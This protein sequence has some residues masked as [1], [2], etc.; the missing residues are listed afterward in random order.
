[1]NEIAKCM[2]IGSALI[3]INCQLAQ[4]LSVNATNTQEWPGTGQTATDAL[5]EKASTTDNTQ[6]YKLYAR[7]LAQNPHC[8]KI[9]LERAKLELKTGATS[10]ALTDCNQALK[11]EPQN[12]LAHL[13]KANVLFCTGQYKS[14]YQQAQLAHKYSTNA[15][16]I[17]NDHL[18][19]IG[20]CSYHLGNY[21]DAI[22][23]LTSSIYGVPTGE[24]YPDALYYRGLTYLKI[25]EDAKALVDFNRS[26]QLRPDRREYLEA[27]ARAYEAMGK[28]DLAK[29]DLAN[30]TKL[31]KT[32]NIVFN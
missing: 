19:I 27:R 32:K 12:T 3:T 11:I 20:A 7:A 2:L 10:K 8:A 25:N 28:V 9:F 1:M 4:T 31:E 23:Y 13:I 5:L 18:R 22:K 24:A 16:E 30:S 6:A 26:I 17:G 21:N 29:V 14:A 15:Y